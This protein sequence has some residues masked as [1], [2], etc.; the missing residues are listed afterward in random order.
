MILNSC[1]LLEIL[2]LCFIFALSDVSD[3]RKPLLGYF[4]RLR[5]SG[6]CFDD[7]VKR[8]NSQLCLLSGSQLVS[9]SIQTAAELNDAGYLMLQ[10]GHYD[11]A[12]FYFQ[13]A[14]RQ[15]PKHAPALSNYG[16]LMVRR[17]QVSLL[18]E[19]LSTSS[20]IHNRQGDSQACADMFCRAVAAAPANPAII[21]NYAMFLGE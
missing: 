12:E 2:Y 14:I 19:N 4:H 6:G 10:R 13:A 1:R 8:E 7:R 17:Q 11:K 9:K 3:N 21:S 5:L 16:R 20:D 18:N 15:D